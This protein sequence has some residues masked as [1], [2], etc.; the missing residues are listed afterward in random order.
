MPKVA[1]KCTKC[2]TYQ[3]WYDRVSVSSTVL[4]LLISLIT[5]TGS[6]VPGLWRWW[7]S[8]NARLDVAF[9]RDDDQGGLFLTATNLGDR[10]GT[11]T[12]VKIK[13]RIKDR[14]FS[15][16]GSL[17]DG[18]DPMIEADHTGNLRYKIDVRDDLRSY[19]VTDVTGLCEL[20]IDVSDN[21]E[22]KPQPIKKDCKDFRP[23]DF[24]R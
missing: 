17:A 16:D 20:I 12:G 10:T 8:G 3:N 9:A 1:I 24:L 6:V 7:E 21:V 23:L 5:V 18:Y 19:H 4:A 11:I 15:Y 2:D 22:P 13:F 14:D